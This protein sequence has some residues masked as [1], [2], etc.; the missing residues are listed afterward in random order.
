[1]QED[2]FEPRR[3]HEGDPTP[4]SSAPLGSGGTENP[5]VEG[6]NEIH[7]PPLLGARELR[8]ENLQKLFD[9]FLYDE[10][11][12]PINQATPQQ[13]LLFLDFSKEIQHL[14]FNG[15]LGYN[16]REPGIDICYETAGFTVDHNDQ[17]VFA[18]QV[19]I[20]SDKDEPLTIGRYDEIEI[21]AGNATCIF[22][23]TPESQEIE[24]LPQLSPQAVEN[25]SDPRCALSSVWLMALESAINQTIHQ[26]V[27]QKVISAEEAKA[28]NGADI[29]EQGYYTIE[30][31]GVIEVR[32]D[33]FLL[34]YEFI[35]DPYGIP[36]CQCREDP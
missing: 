21:H 34:L 30:S 27:D 11:F 24:I 4:P 7:L 15:L 3:K 9:E 16:E 29:I 22:I 33:N 10:G 19:F 28:L 2:R 6:S 35:V 20:R 12:R 18:L 5:R 25:I 32:I 8:D 31:E 13:H 1:M 14:V 26:M 17:P 23:G 36:R